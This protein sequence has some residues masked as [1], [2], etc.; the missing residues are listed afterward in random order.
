MDFTESLHL[1]IPSLHFD[2][3]GLHF[4]VIVPPGLLIYHYV[5]QF[6]RITK[7]PKI[8]GVTNFKRDK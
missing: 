3:F 6:Y 5:P 4:Y 2:P 1:S 7:I 8:G